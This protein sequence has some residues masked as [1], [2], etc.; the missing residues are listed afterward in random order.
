MA[1]FC[2]QC[3]LEIFGEDFKEC[4]LPE[5]SELRGTLPPEHGWAALCEGCGPTIVDDEGVCI[6]PGCTRH[7]T[8]AAKDDC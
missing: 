4:A 7:G 8:E 6:N 1:D 5:G 3:S 2:K